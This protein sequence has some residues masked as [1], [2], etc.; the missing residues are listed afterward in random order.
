M[1]KTQLL[2]APSH[3][4]QGQAADPLDALANFVTRH[5]RLFILTGAGCSTAS[6]IPDYRDAKGEWKRRQPVQY[7]D[8]IRSEPVR[9]RYWARSMVGWPQMAQ[10]CPNGAH[11]GLVRL[12]RA[13]LVHQLVTQNVDGLHQQ[14][15]SS[16]VIDLHGRLDTVECLDCRTRFSREKFQHTLLVANPDFYHTSVPRA[17]DGDADL[18]NVDFE[19]FKIPTCLKCGGLVKPSVVFFG[20]SVPRP[21][22]ELAYQRLQKADA[23]LVIGSSLMVFSGYR[24]CRSAVE[25]KKPIAAVN[26]G[27]T[28]ADAEL[29]LKVVGSCVELLPALVARLGV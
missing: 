11:Y 5:Q 15:G 28:R 7:Q 12:Q 29:T 22:V 1:E 9:R 23:L 26:L 16:Q 21:R 10:A 18:E 25:Q 27:R 6:G 2:H 19:Q 8:F 4:T 3:V 20:E 13:G 17:P 24:F 14:A